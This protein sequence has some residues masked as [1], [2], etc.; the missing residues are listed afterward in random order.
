MDCSLPSFLVLHHLP[1]FAH[2]PVYFVG[3][4]IQPSHPLLP[5][6]L[7]SVFASI[8]VLSSES[9]LHIR[10]PE[11]WSFSF[12]FSPSNEYSSLISFR[13]NWFDLLAVPRTLKSLLQHHSSKASILQC[14]VF[15]TFQVSYPYLTTGKIR[16][17]TTGTFVDKVIFLLFTRLSRFVIAFLPRSKHL[18]ISWLQSLSTMILKPK[19]NEICH[20][21]HFSPSICHEVMGLNAMIL[22]F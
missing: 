5:P 22:V 2:T 14:S 13:I 19:K 10:W 20:C 12:S 16:A 11:F 18:L 3:C 6:L 21:F 8:R 1:E 9:V 15:F 7:L 17:L 4:A